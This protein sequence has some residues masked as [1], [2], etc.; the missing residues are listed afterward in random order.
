MSYGT[1]HSINEGGPYDQSPKPARPANLGGDNARPNSRCSVDDLARHHGPIVRRTTAAPILR[2]RT[3]DCGAVVDRSRQY[4]DRL[5]LSSAIR[6]S[7]NSLVTS[8]SG[9][10]DCRKHS[11]TRE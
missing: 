8:S 1:T 9:A 3:G 7:G 6:F 2:R 11:A 4:A 5:R 10:F